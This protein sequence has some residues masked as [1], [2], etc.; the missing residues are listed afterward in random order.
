MSGAGSSDGFSADFRGAQE[1]Q[2]P[3]FLLRL[4]EM[5][6][7]DAD[8]LKAF[9]RTDRQHYIPTIPDYE[10]W[11]DQ[12][13]D[14]GFGQSSGLPSTTAIMIH[15]L[16]LERHHKVLQIGFGSGFQTALLAR[17]ARR[18]YGL[19]RIRSM[20]RRAEQ[21]LLSDNIRNVTLLSGDGYAGWA[22][23]APFDRIIV[24][25]A[26]EEVPAAL[27]DQLTESGVLVAP[28]I[29][30]QGEEAIT[31]FSSGTDG[32]QDRIIARAA[33]SPLI[34]GRVVDG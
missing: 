21:R 5:G 1:H 14:I 19:D 26:C 34:A 18:V 7:S 28:I 9:E 15:C 11:M 3:A 4:R 32:V 12:D 24:N 22:A 16:R 30:D 10:I 17:L 2:L 29:D 13:Q 25:A 27:F 20:T 31:A 23:Q 33:F 6:I 8:L